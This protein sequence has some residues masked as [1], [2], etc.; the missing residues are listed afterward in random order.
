[1]SASRFETSLELLTRVPGVRGAMIVSASDGVVVAEALMDEMRGSAVAAL[2]ASL[3]SRL[4]RAVEG[5]GRGAP[6]F[7]HLTASGG[8]LLAAPHGEDLLL[9]AVGERSVNAGLV[10]IEMFRALELLA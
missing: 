5:S 8:T 6:R 9:V 3:A 2:A 7:V 4:K 1:M 10:R